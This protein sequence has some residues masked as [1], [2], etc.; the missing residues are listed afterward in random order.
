MHSGQEWRSGE[1]LA[2]TERE[3]PGRPPSGPSRWVTGTLAAVLGVTFIGVLGSDSLC[4]EH[5][6]WVQALA[7][8][9]FFGVGAALV[10][11]WRGWAGAPLLTLVASLAGVVI[12]LLDTVHSPTRGQFVALGFALSAVLAASMTWRAQRLVRWD[13]ATLEA[14]SGGDE[15]TAGPV[16]ATSDVAPATTTELGAPTVG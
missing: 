10:A 14:P 13:R 11:L 1:V 16:T 15:A 2:F 7:G 12:G 6:A 3:G 4:P 8:F 5:R 9:A